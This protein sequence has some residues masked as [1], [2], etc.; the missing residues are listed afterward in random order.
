MAIRKIVKYII[1]GFVQ[2]FTEPLPVSSSAHLVIASHYLGLQTDLNTE[3]WLHFASFWALAWFF[4]KDLWGMA[5]SVFRPKQYPEDFRTVLNLLIASLPIVAAGLLLKD[6]IERSFND[7]KAVCLFLL[8]T[9]FVLVLT[10][11]LINRNRKD[12]PAFGD[13]LIIGIFQS[14][15]IFPGISRSAVTFL[16]TKVSKLETKPA[17]KFSFY[18]CLIASFGAFVLALKD[19]D[20]SAFSAYDLITFVV[21]FWATLLGISFLERIISQKSLL[22]FSLYAMA[23]SVLVFLTK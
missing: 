3:I 9:S 8:L 2:G 18:L 14:L 17:L 20:F 11:F 12:S 1:L 19:F 16:G 4:R 7:V 6:T 22:V 15:A 13:S 21:C 5:K 23:L 10:A